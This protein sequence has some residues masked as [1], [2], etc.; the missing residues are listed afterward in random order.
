MA[1]GDMEIGEDHDEDEEIIDGEG[2]LYE[3]AGEELKALFRP[4]I[5]IYSDVE[6]DREGKPDDGPGQCLAEP[7]LVA[8]SAEYPHVQGEHYGHDGRKTDPQCCLARH[9]FVPFR[10]GKI[11]AIISLL[12]NSIIAARP[13]QSPCIF[14]PNLLPSLTGHPLNSSIFLAAF[15]I[16]LLAELGD[17]PS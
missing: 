3:I 15:G 16:V 8:L 7:D 5:E 4:Q 17:K 11:I 12:V 2:L 14:Q 9:P 1:P 10:K 6:G 13:C